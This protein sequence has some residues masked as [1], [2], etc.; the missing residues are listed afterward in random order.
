[1]TKKASHYESK[2]TPDEIGMILKEEGFSL[3]GTERSVKPRHPLEPGVP[4]VCGQCQKDMG[5]R[6]IIASW[7]YKGQKKYTHGKRCTP[8]YNAYYARRKQLV[9]TTI[10]RNQ[11]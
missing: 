6:K 8:C 10:D 3:I 11:F 1:M 9:R 2:L 5:P 4:L 7:T